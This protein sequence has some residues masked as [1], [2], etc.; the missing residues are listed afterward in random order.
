MSRSFGIG[1]SGCGWIAGVHA[2]AIGTLRS[3]VTRRIAYA[4]AYALLGAIYER[5]GQRSK[6]RQTYELAAGNEGLSEQDRRGFRAMAERL[7]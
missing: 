2:G 1:I 6:A 5:Q 4:D 3:M 7:R